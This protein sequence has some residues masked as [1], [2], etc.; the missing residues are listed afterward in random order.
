MDIAE[1][2]KCGIMEAAL[3]FCKDN[4]LEPE[5]LVSCLDGLTIERIKKDAI[6]NRAIQKRVMGKIPKELPFE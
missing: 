5:D 3:E 4:E 1:E 2:L 6:E